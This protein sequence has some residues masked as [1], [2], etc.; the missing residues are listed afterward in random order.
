MIGIKLYEFYPNNNIIIIKYLVR[1]FYNNNIFNIIVNQ[2]YIL[3]NRYITDV[4]SPYLYMIS[5]L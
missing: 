3:N 4:I 2:N 1:I 5:N